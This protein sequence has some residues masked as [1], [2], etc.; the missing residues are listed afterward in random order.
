VTPLH[1]QLLIS[2][3]LTRADEAV[4]KRLRR[5]A[6]VA[7]LLVLFTGVF[8]LIY[9]ITSTAA[10]ARWSPRWRARRAAR[11]LVF[12][13]AACADFVVA[14]TGARTLLALLRLALGVAGTFALLM[15]PEI[16]FREESIDTTARVARL[17]AQRRRG[18]TVIDLEGLP[19]RLAHRPRDAPL[20]GRG[21][22]PLEEF[23]IVLSRSLRT[24]VPGVLFGLLFVLPALF[25]SRRDVLG[26]FPAMMGDRDGDAVRLERLQLSTCVARSIASTRCA[27]CRCR[28]R[29]SCS[30][31]W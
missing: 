22:D 1:L 7:L 4:A 16:D 8:A 26:I 31:S 23:S 3:L 5:G 25:A 6:R 11:V 10:S 29:R 14:D 28:R 30:P 24:V 20:L 18:E 17:L 13:A 15:V 27:R 12:P 2:V 21:R 9:T 19:R